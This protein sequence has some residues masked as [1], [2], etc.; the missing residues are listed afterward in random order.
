[1]LRKIGRRKRGRQ[2]MRW[3]DGITDSMDMSL[4]EFQE[5][6][7]D[8][9]AWYAAI[10]RVTK[11][12]TWLR[13][14]SDLIWSIDKQWR[15]QTF[16]GKNGNRTKKINPF[17]ILVS[18][19]REK[20]H[21]Y[22]ILALR[23]QDLHTTWPDRLETTFSNPSSDSFL[24]LLSTAP[25]SHTPFHFFFFLSLPPT[26]SITHCLIAWF[27]HQGP[28]LHQEWK[29]TRVRLLPS[30]CKKQHQRNDHLER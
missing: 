18:L 29:Y 17:F 4:S 7:M 9:E 25:L 10:H 8:R 1:M 23:C 19:R 20:K 13:D 24:P 28:C 30:F 5:L 15:V 27:A 26:H 21:F 3:M 12:R 11:S 16:R 14:W 2:R 22:S 6:V